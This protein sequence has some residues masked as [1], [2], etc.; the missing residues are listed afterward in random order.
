MTKPLI[1]IADD[2]KAL[3]Q[4][5]AVRF[6]RHGYRTI[7]AVNGGDALALAR[8]DAP[9]VMLLDINMPERG[10]DVHRRKRKFPDLQ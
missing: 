3:L 1:L 10:L 8:D 9:D 7:T 4:M 2:D 6:D 5:L